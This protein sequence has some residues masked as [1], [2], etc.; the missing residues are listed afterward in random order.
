MND[1]GNKVFVFIFILKRG[2][3]FSGLN[4]D[5]LYS[6]IHIT[7]NFDN[8]VP[9]DR[10][11]FEGTGFFLNGS[12]GKISLVTNRH[13]L[14]L[15]YS[16]PKLNSLGYKLKFVQGIYRNKN[17]ISGLPDNYEQL[18]MLDVNTITFP[19]SGEDLAIIPDPKF[20]KDIERKSLNLE[21]TIPTSF[22]ANEDVF[23]N[24]NTCVGDVVSYPGFP[25]WFDKKNYRPILR[26]GSIASDPRY[27]YLGNGQLGPGD[28]LAYEAFSY[29]GSSGSPIFAL[30]K[31]LRVN[32]SFS[33][34]YRKFH[35]VGINCG[36]LVIEATSLRAEMGLH[37]GISYFLKSPL[38]ISELKRLNV[39]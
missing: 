33:D 24:P 2:Q 6:V 16:N 21:Y 8:G 30:Q 25:E 26:S 32:H 38:I 37:S 3:M 10:K 1:N 12:N 14:D 31:G 22:L 18:L 4:N 7:A 23:F 5:F 17:L 28:H 29:G 19:Q 9:E 11:S 36:H 20:I 15:S 35:L 13:V 27:P 34:N 39:Y